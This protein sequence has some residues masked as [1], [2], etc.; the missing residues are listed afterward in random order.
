MSLWL[1]RAG[2]HGEQ[3]QGAL[4]NSV[5]TIGWNELPDLSK[6]KDKNELTKLYVQIHP[7]AKKNQIANEVG[8]VWRFAYDIQLGDLVALPLKTQSA[9]AIGKVE[10]PYEYKEA[11]WI[12]GG[13]LIILGL[14][15]IRMY[16]IPFIKEL[17]KR[18]KHD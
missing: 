11:R 18:K 5:V 9:I 13:L 16:T 15:G 3:E 7:K 17:L 2:R 10:G 8:Q 6:L 1:V 4:D 12:I 14:S